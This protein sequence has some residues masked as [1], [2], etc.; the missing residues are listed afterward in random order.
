MV[1]TDALPLELANEWQEHGVDGDSLAYLQ[2]T[3]G[4][5]AAPKGVMIATP[6]ASQF[7]YIHQGCSTARQHLLTWLPHFTTWACST[8]SFNP[9][10]AASWVC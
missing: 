7:A 5:T 2:Y 1:T 3:S 10:T 8:A 9:C 4:S 6:R